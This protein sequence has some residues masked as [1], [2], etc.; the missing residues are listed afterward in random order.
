M[1]ADNTEQRKKDAELIVSLVADALRWRCCLEKGFPIAFVYN[2]CHPRGISADQVRW[3][4]PNSST[5]R[6]KHSG[7]YRTPE[8]AV[9][10]EITEPQITNMT[11]RVRHAVKA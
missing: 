4:V 6:N 7:G 5:G 3:V 9:N 2:D 1:T 11:N 10:A 8:L